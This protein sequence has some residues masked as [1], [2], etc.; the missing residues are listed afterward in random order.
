MPK[1]VKQR[2]ANPVKD[3][4]ASKRR[5]REITDHARPGSVRRGAAETVTGRGGSPKGHR[6]GADT[7]H[8]GQRGGIRFDTPDREEAMNSRKGKHAGR[9]APGSGLVKAPSREWGPGEGRS[10]TGKTKGERRRAKGR[11]GH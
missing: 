9:K 1:D 5:T 7:G 4:G 11:R 3:Q 10:R 6:R 2:M 8:P